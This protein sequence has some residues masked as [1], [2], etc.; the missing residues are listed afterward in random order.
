MMT[1]NILVTGGAGYIGSHVCKALA[2]TGYT[3]VVYDNLAR[4]HA[5]AV[6]WGALEIGDISDAMHLRQV[7]NKYQPAAVMHFAA[8]AYVGESV[9]QPLKYYTNNFSGTFCLLKV[10]HDVCIDKLVFSSTCATYGIPIWV[11][12]TED[13]P[14]QPINPYGMSKL[15]VERVLSDV[16]KA[17]KLHCV[18][19][20]Y[21]NAAGADPD[22]EIGE[23]HDPETHLI[24]LVLDAA[25]GKLT[26]VTVYGNDYV[27]RDGTC[28]RDYIHVADL[29]QAHLLALKSLLCGDGRGSYET[30]K[31]DVDSAGLAPANSSSL[32]NPFRVYNLGNGQGFSVRDVIACAEKVTG[33]V[34]PIQI[35]KRRQGDPPVLISDAEKAIREL[36]WKP[37]YADLEQIIRTAW[38]W[39][40]KT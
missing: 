5:S 10:M 28:V 4:G 14:Q 30:E 34:V 12:I 33:R 3:P 36:G 1:N 23:R 40:Q 18:V 38:E 11:P 21:F 13:H 19:L 2:Q 20:R 16:S 37:G 22:A 9:E 15:M 25:A 24:P 31:E 8:L 27:T 39:H 6:K 29:A 17:S 26:H 32:M 35:G 7:I